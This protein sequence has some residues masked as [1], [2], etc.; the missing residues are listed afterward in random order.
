MA[1]RRTGLVW[2]ERY[3]WHLAGSGAAFLPPGGLV[4]P[5]VPVDEPAA[6][7]RIRNLLEVSGML[8]RLTPIA[9]RA[10]SEEELLRFHRAD[11][12]D[13]IRELSAAGG[14]DAGEMTPLG[15]DSFEI[16]Q[17][18]A[19]GCLAAVDA[20]LGGEV[21]NAYALVR[22]CGHHAE[23]ARGRGSAIFANGVLSAL[24]GRQVH[25]L[26]RVAIVDFDVHHGNS[27]QLA[28]WD[29]PSVL[30]ISVH[31]ERYFPPE[32]GAVEELGEGDGAGFNLNLPLPAGSGHAA[33]LAAFERAVLPA[34][35]AFSPQLVLVAAGFDANAIDPMGR[36]LLYSE[37]FR[38]MTRALLA[39]AEESAAGRLVMFHEGGY[40]AAYVP[41]CCHAAIEELAGVRVGEDPFAEF[42]AGTAGQELRPWQEEALEAP[43]AN[44]RRLA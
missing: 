34:L 13:R 23:P 9:P 1:A 24:H 3:V 44:A 22:P 39:V 20:V 37:S 14:G 2:H 41:F 5:G 12:V 15:P 26:E 10:A 40:S 38:E 29:D 42:F 7:R 35:R 6:K 17:L 33:Y 18:A 8:D 43:A 21:D 31:Q 16:A 30:T 36:M 28:F 25:G 32:G 19:G 4:E 11:Y 27:A